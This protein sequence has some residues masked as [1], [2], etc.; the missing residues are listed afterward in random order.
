MD[1]FVTLD[2]VSASDSYPN[3]GK[4]VLK[5]LSQKAMHSILGNSN[6]YD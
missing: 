2:S 5:A 3:F 1:E 6:G 4:L